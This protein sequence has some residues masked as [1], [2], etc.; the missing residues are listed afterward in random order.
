VSKQGQPQAWRQAGRSDRAGRGERIRRSVCDFV[1]AF[2]TGAGALLGLVLAFPPDVDP[3]PEPLGDQLQRV[4]IPTLG[5]ALIGMTAGAAIGLA[6][7]VWLPGLRDP[8]RR[9]S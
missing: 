5:P 8:K 4:L 7:C 3:V 1:L 9:S 2:C 6:L